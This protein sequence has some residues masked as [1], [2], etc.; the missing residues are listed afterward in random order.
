[1]EPDHKAMIVISHP[2]EFVPKGSSHLN[3][4]TSS[5]NT[6]ADNNKTSI[7]GSSIGNNGTIA[8]TSASTAAMPTNAASITG[9]ANNADLMAYSTNL[10]EKNRITLAH[11]NLQR[12]NIKLMINSE[13]NNSSINEIS[14]IH[15]Q[16]TPLI[17]NMN[18]ELAVFDFLY[19]Y[20]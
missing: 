9:A 6:K 4:H 20:Y 3:Y 17:N 13:L 5:S 18:F 8:G 15:W 11:A 16:K 19:I 2:W 14:F 12:K 10:N 1:M 7:A